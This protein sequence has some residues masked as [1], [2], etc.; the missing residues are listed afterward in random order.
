MSAADYAVIAAIGM[1]FFLLVMGGVIGFVIFILRALGDIKKS[2][3]SA[4]Q[5]LQAIAPQFKGDEITRLANAMILMGKLG[6]NM[7]T[8]MESLDK[9]INLFYTFAVANKGIQEEVRSQTPSPVGGGR[10]SAM[11]DDKAAELEAVRN[12]QQEAEQ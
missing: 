12:A 2:L 7:V 1:F 9:V 3:D 4:T 8:K 6:T 5:A 11:S 10:F